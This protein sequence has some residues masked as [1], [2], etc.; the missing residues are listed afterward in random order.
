[1]ISGGLQTAYV[2]SV[3]QYLRE[4]SNRSHVEQIT[5]SRDFL[6]RLFGSSFAPLLPQTRHDSPCLQFSVCAII[7]IKILAVG[8]GIRA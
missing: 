7:F 6:A 5:D 3:A 8:I 2:Q 1:M 4:L